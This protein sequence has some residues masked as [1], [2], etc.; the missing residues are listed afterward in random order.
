M[1]RDRAQGSPSQ[2][3]G[4]HPA[5]PRLPLVGIRA[6]KDF[7]QQEKDGR[8]EPGGVD[9]SLEA[10]HLGVEVTDA[11]SERVADFQ[12][13]AHGEGRQPKRGRADGGPRKASTAL[14]PIER[15]SVLLPD[16]FDPVTSRARPGSR[17]GDVVRHARVVPSS[18]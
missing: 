13:R 4:Q 15:S 14:I 6:M 16:M 9:H 8:L 7:V 18:G 2:E 17:K 3:F 11:A 5:R 10:R 1:R 12:A